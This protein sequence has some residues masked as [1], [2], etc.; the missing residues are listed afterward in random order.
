MDRAGAFRRFT[1]RADV[2]NRNKEL[3]PLAIH[4]RQT[5]GGQYVDAGLDRVVPASAR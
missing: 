5:T 3:V 2:S 4:C 1:A